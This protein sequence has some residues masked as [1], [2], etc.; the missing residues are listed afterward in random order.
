MRVLNG[1]VMV[2]DLVENRIGCIHEVGEVIE[3]R[4]DD[5]CIVLRNEYIGK[6]VASPE[7]CTIVEK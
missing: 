5:D 4:E 6:W 2:G 1:F 7:K 3:I